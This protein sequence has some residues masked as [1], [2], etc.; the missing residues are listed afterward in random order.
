MSDLLVCILRAAKIP[1]KIV[2]GWTIDLET[3][4]LNPHAWC[5]FFSPRANGWRQC[6]PT[7]GYLTGVSCQH[8]CRQREGLSPDQHTFTWSYLGDAKIS[9]Q[10]HIN[11]TVIP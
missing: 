1:A 5:E 4:S 6:D 2:H 7:W 8:I 10:E 3:H 9:V 11:L